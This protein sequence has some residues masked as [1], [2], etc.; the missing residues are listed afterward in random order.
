LVAHVDGLLAKRLPFI[1]YVAEETTAFAYTIGLAALDIPDLIL[2]API[3][4][5]LALAV[6]NGIGT[7]WLADPSSMRPG[8]VEG[9]ISL[10]VR[11]RSI[12]DRAK[13]AERA[14]YAVQYNEFKELVAPA[15]LQVFL[16]DDAGLFPGDVRYRWEKQ[17]RL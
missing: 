16:P 2:A 4:P 5:D 7:R 11:V 6:L 10:P 17:P 9:I 3:N 8:D 1:Q 12:D 15:P 14:L 13:Y